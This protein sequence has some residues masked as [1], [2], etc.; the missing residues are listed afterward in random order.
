MT[1]DIQQAAGKTVP[2]PSRRTWLVS[3]GLSAAGIAFLLSRVDV[4]SIGAALQQ[5]DYGMFGLSLLLAVLVQFITPWRWRVLLDNQISLRHSTSAVFVGNFISALV[6]LRGGEVVRAVMAQKIAGVNLMQ[7]VLTIVITQVF[8]LLLLAL[9]GFSLLLVAPLPPE[10]A[11][12]ALVTGLLVLAVAAGL[13]GLMLLPDTH[14]QT[15]ARLRALAGDRIYGLASRL[16]GRISAGLKL[17][18]DPSMFAYALALSVLFWIITTLSGAVLL[19]GWLDSDV[20]LAGAMMAFTGGVGRILPALPGSL[21][22][23]DALVLLGLTAL[24]IDESL[25]LAVVVLL[26]V[27]YTLMVI[28]TGVIGFALGS[29]ARA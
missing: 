27:R 9:L 28:I 24:G 10:L 26:R 18:T 13:V 29:T 5:A 20:L 8:D 1:T 11:Q 19:L 16:V 12:A 6:P 15:K 14:Q 7:S 23:L 3:G 2:P 22:T 4:E 25:A 21:G 17:L